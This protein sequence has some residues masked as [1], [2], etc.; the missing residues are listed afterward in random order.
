MTGS[1]YKHCLKYLDGNFFKQSGIAYAIESLRKVKSP[2]DIRIGFKEVGFSGLQLSEVPSNAIV[3]RSSVGRTPTYRRFRRSPSRHD[4]VSNGRQP[5]DP[6]VDKLSLG[7]AELSMVG[8]WDI[9]IGKF[10]KCNVGFREF[11]VH[12]GA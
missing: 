2:Q 12:Y 10:L 7:Q 6:P 11:L 1:S 5:L 8:N 9:T 3:S 4:V